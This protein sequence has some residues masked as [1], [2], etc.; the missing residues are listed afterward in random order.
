MITP[1]PGRTFT[2]NDDRRGAELA[3]LISEPLWARKFNSSA[4]II[5]KS[6]TLDDKNRV[7]GVIPSSLLSRNT[8]VYVPIGA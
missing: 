6:I 4:D 2:A 7:V 5:G 8:D 1:A 3:V